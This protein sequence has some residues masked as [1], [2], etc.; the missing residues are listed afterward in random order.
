M[1]ECLINHNVGALLMLAGLIA[2][3][4][5]LLKIEDFVKNFF[6]RG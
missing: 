1:L 2:V 5:L 6:K 4:A 3:S